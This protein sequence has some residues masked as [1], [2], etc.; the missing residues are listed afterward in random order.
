MVG[1]DTRLCND[2]NWSTMEMSNVEILGWVAT[3]F[4]IVSFLF[5]GLKL[6]VLNTIGAVLWLYYGYLVNSNSIMFLNGTLIVIQ[7]I[8]MYQLQKRN[9]NL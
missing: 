6:R 9:I 5:E 8:K 3:M 7:F 2:Y 4:I 1:R